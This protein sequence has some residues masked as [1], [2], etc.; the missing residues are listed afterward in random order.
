MDS[1][2]EIKS[3]MII[4]FSSIKQRIQDKKNR[5]QVLNIN[6]YQSHNISSTK[7]SSIKNKQT[8]TK[9][10][11]LENKAKHYKRKKN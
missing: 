1:F 8:R 10:N 3:G 11:I 9:I 5:S 6:N 7:P 4:F 2:K